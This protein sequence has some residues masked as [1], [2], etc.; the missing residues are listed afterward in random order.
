MVVAGWGY[1]DRN[2]DRDKGQGQGW[3][4]GRGQGQGQRRWWYCRVPIVVIPR[5]LSF[6]IPAISEVDICFRR[7]KLNSAYVVSQGR[8]VE[9]LTYVPLSGVI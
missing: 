2:R 3:G 8:L 7:L 9:V 1:R 5:L 6:S 4:Q